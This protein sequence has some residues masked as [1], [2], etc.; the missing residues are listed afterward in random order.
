[1][2]ALYLED[3]TN[4]SNCMLK[5]CYNLRE[6][7]AKPCSG[8]LRWQQSRWMWHSPHLRTKLELPLKYRN[9]L[10]NQ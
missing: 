2:E 7:C 1:M 3:F 6:V 10:D 5:H 9:H 8:P 4:I